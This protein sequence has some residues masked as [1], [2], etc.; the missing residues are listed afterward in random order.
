MLSIFV[1][2]LL[3]APFPAEIVKRL[4]FRYHSY[5][6]GVKGCSSIT[7][8][9]R[10]TIGVIVVVNIPFT[11]TIWL[12]IHSNTHNWLAHQSPKELQRLPC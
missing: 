3:V 6:F 5:L 2:S 7:V 4:L 10:F 11:R 1:L 12:S 8:K 9:D